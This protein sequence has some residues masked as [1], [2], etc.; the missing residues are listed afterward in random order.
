MSGNEISDIQASGIM[1]VDRTPT[2]LLKANDTAGKWYSVGDT[3]RNYRVRAID[4]SGGLVV[5][6]DNEGRSF[7]ILLPAEKISQIAAEMPPRLT[8]AENLDWK[9]IRSEQNP[10]RKAPIPLPE[11]AVLAWE[12]GGEKF[13][14][15]FKNYYRAHGWEISNVQGKLGGRVRQDFAPLTNPSDRVRTKEEIMRTALPISGMKVADPSEQKS[16]K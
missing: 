8:P 3:I 15:D 7:E 11:W 12:D 1:V 2:A 13:R 9:W 5:L 16:K 6:Q 10:M 14:I 4:I